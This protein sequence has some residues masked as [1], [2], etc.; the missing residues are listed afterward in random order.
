MKVKGKWGYLYGAVGKGSDA[1][2]FYLLP[3]R[4]TKA[5]KRFLAKALKGV[6]DCRYLPYQGIFTIAPHLVSV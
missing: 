5:A 4:I 6:R 1:F 3:K 2:D